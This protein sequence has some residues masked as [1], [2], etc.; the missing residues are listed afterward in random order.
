VDKEGED[1]VK[2]QSAQTTVIGVENYS[3]LI[4]IVKH[5]SV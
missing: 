5:L 4:N 1:L 2:L 3:V